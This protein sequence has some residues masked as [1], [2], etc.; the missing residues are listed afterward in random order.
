V[1]HSGW[2][3]E[4]VLVDS[5]RARHRAVGAAACGAGGEEAWGR[6][7]GRHMADTGTRQQRVSSELDVERVGKKLGAAL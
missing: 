6:H 4:K 1:L 3:R 5:I 2:H 7:C